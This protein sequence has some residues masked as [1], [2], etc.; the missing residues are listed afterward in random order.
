MKYIRFPKYRRFSVPLQSCNGFAV[1]EVLCED[2]QRASGNRL[3]YFIVQMKAKHTSDE[4]KSL[5]VSM[6]AV[7]TLRQVL[8]AVTPLATLEMTPADR[9]QLCETVLDFCTE[10]NGI[11]QG[12]IN[13]PLEEIEKVEAEAKTNNVFLYLEATERYIKSRM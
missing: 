4:A 9:T 12:A 3:F 2:G 5:S 1:P 13:M 10:V 11:I 7:K 8:T 6:N